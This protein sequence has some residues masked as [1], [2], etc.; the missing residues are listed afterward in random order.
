MRHVFKGV[1]LTLGL[2][3]A[4]GTAGCGSSECE[5]PADCEGSAGEGQQW[6]CR[7]EKCEREPLTVTCTADQAL[8]NGACVAC[9]P[10]QVA[11][12]DKR[13]C[14]ACPSGQ[15]ELAAGECRACP[16]G[17]APTQDRTSCA[18]IQCVADQVLE[19]DRCVTC[20][21]GQ[22]PSGDTRSCVPCAADQ[23]ENNGTC[24]ACGPGQV[25]SQDKLS[26]VACA[27]N[28]IEQ[29]AACVA[30]P[31][32]QV[33]S[34]ARD[35]CVT[36]P[37][38]VAYVRFVNA[39]LG[40]KNNASDSETAAWDPYKI[41]VYQGDTRLFASVGPGDAAVTEY[42]EVP[43]GTLTFVAKN[44]EDATAPDVASSGAVTLAA[45]E[46]L[47]L[48][49]MAF[50]NNSDVTDVRRAR[51]LALK[52][53]FSTPATGAAQVVVV[54]ADRVIDNDAEGN[55]HSRTLTDVT[56]TSGEPVAISANAY[57]QSSAGGV[58][59]PVTASRFELS[60][61]DS[62]GFPPATNKRMYF[63]VPSGRMVAGSS[64]FVIVTGDARRPLAD[65]GQPAL[66][67]VR[68]GSNEFVRVRRDPIVY[69]FNALLPAE[70][71]S[72]SPAL[73]VL[74]SDGRRVVVNMQYNGATSV[75]ELPPTETGQALTVTENEN[76][77]ATV[78]QSQSGALLAGRRYLVVVTGQAGQ[79]GALAPRSIFVPDT[80]AADALDAR[81]RVVNAIPNA[82]AGGVGFGHF[83]VSGNTRADPF[84][85]VVGGVAYGAVGA[86]DEGVPFA[87]P[88]TSN[89]RVF[90]GLQDTGDGA[91]PVR[92]AQ[93]NSM[94]R[95]H[96]VVLLGSWASPTFRAFN[97]RSNSWAAI[98]PSAAFANP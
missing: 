82:P 36:P 85:P 13:S 10:G 75:G 96:L 45:G 72:Q 26:C 81:V 7:E 23:R 48:V 79:T 22:V 43:V 97:V 11:A 27:A 83:A 78:L 1:V 77:S 5:A 98:S 89:R 37:P 44:A 90:Y 42:K 30:C 17:Q 32:G 54:S 35:A 87:P 84:T 52:E 33:P 55:P 51:L 31:A 80:F 88:T 29:N 39:F 76:D 47:T 41:D 86:G 53:S 19:N 16:S 3:L 8:S 15:A 65:E 70:G 2:V 73:Q 25:V 21:A 6:V 56:S 68:A 92:W 69:F 57:S 34:D 4:V 14:V 93:G 24:V 94:S 59:V 67:L 62:T 38:T 60:S 20:S 66:L 61:S 46:R 28:E 58:S 74:R 64:W 9:G 91:A 95:P 50:A 18:P 63:T 12:G 49:T 71:Q 40:L